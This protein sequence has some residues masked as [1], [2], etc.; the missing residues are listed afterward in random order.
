M[1]S[2]VTVL[3]LGICATASAAG[4]DGLR[5]HFA[6][7]RSQLDGRAQ[8]ALRR[9]DG[10]GPQLLA[11]RAYLRA[12][13]AMNQRWS[14]TEEQISAYQG[15]PAQIALDAEVAKVRI[16][17]EKANPGYS[18]FVN[19]HV[20]SLDLQLQRWNQ[21]A[22]VTKASHHM[23]AAMQAAIR[24]PGFPAPGSPAAVSRFQQVVR[25]Y[26]PQPIPT[27]AAP[28]LSAHGRMNAVDFQIRQGNRTIAAPD[29]STVGS[30]WIS[31]GWR[32]RLQAAVHAAGARFNGPLASPDEPWHYD[33][34]P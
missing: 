14:W 28:G 32:D 15:S 20:R 21:T 12:G 13:P 4:Q 11:T 6:A 22:S 26:R 33:Y 19:P 5:E 2:V 30:V 9:I 23:A 34:R 27:L 10:L 24:E 25:D 8:F 3:L 18:L 16:A 1:R 7:L 31:Q 29:S 17:F